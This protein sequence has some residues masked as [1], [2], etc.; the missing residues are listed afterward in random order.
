MSDVR[1]TPFFTEAFPEYCT[2]AVHG[3]TP[4]GALSLSGQVMP[5]YFD[6]PL[7]PTFGNSIQH[8]LL[9]PKE[10]ELGKFEESYLRPHQTTMTLSILGVPQ[11]A[12]ELNRFCLLI[13]SYLLDH[14]K[15]E[16]SK[17]RPII[18]RGQG[19]PFISHL[20]LIATEL[21]LDPT[22]ISNRI[23]T[24]S[25]GF[26]QVSPSTK[27]PSLDD[28]IPRALLQQFKTHWKSKTFSPEERPMP[29]QQHAPQRMR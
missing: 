6:G 7:A 21:G 19:S 10:S 2:R 20:Q 17:P 3:S 11:S 27:K 24:Y 12:R 5:G 9:S 1:S 22:T 25:P 4:H 23:T 18:A 26:F 28:T 8:I 13:L 16:P 15:Y 14:L 29:V